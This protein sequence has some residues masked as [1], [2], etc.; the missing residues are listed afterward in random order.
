[1]MDE[2]DG[3]RLKSV[4]RSDGLMRLFLGGEELVVT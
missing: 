4:A 2:E 1:M 3:E